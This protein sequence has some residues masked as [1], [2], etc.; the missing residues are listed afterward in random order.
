MRSFVKNTLVRCFA[1]SFLLAVSAPVW[2]QSLSSSN[3]NAGVAPRSTDVSGNIGFSNLT[4]VDGNN[5]ADFGFAA[6]INVSNRG[7][8]LAEYNYLGGGSLD[9]VSARTQLLGIADRISFPTSTLVTPYLVVGGGYARTSTSVASD[10]FGDAVS[11]GANGLYLGAGGGASIYL[12]KGWGVRPELRIER[13]EFYNSGSSFG[14]TVA[15]FSVAA[16]YQFGGTAR[17]N[18]R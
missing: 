13:E 18:N 5:H 6:G 1:I 14:N 15:R 2:A 10:Y 16:F 17:K 11:Y 8:V 4:G 12:G 9:G 7:A 3:V